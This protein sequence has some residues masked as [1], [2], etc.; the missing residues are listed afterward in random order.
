MGNQTFF[1][2][3]WGVGGKS[4]VFHFPVGGGWEIKCIQFPSGGRV[5]NQMYSISQWGG[6]SG[7]SSLCW[8]RYAN[9]DNT[10]LNSRASRS[11]AKTGSCSCLFWSFFEVEK[12]IEKM[13]SKGPQ[14]DPKSRPKSTERAFRRG[15]EKGTQKG[16]LSRSRK[17]EILLLFTTL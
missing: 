1:T 14:R 10:S 7:S 6:G 13:V 5:G 16:T 4:N 9:V 11:L 17:S 8:D 15:L 2:S 12:S 3:Q